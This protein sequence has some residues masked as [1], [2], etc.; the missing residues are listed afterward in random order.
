MGF[1]SINCSIEELNHVKRGRPVNIE[2][3]VTKCLSPDLKTAP[4]YKL[5]PE[6][7]GIFLIPANFV[8]SAKSV[9]GLKI[10]T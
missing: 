4:K 6:L 7:I 2:I 1:F 5:S 3:F 10:Q 8:D 9:S